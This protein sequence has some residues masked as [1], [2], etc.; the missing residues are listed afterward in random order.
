MNSLLPKGRYRVRLVACEVKT[1]A[2]GRRYLVFSAVVVEGPFAGTKLESQKAF[3]RRMVPTV[4]GV[5]QLVRA[6]GFRQ[7]R[8]DN[9]RV[10][11]AAV[12]EARMFEVD[13]DWQGFDQRHYTTNRP[14]ARSHAAW[15]R[16]QL[17]STI[18]GLEKFETDCACWP[19]AFGPSNEPVQAWAVIVK[20]RLPKPARRK[21]SNEHD[22]KDDSAAAG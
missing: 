12:A 3:T 22:R 15:R 10:L 17:E 9:L 7:S 18:V 16:L 11:R 4:L 8:K 19:W 20:C 14:H 6:L 2:N 1:T 5:S 13:V 21:L